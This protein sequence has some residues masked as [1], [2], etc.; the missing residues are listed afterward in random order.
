MSKLLAAFLLLAALTFPSAARDL[1]VYF[2]DV[3]GGQAT[4]V[5]APSGQSLLID[6]GWPGFAGRDPMRIV[7]AAREAGLKQIDYLLVTHYH[8]DHA[9][10]VPALA[11]QF[12][13]RHF[14]DHGPSVETGQSAQD[15]FTAYRRVREQGRH[16]V[17]K[18]GQAIP[19]EGLGIRILSSA[20]RVLAAPPAGAGQA[21]PLCAQTAPQPED[22]GEN[23]QSVGIL[24]TYGKFRLLDLGDLTWNRELEL[25]CPAN[26][27]GPVDVYLTTHHGGDGSGPAAL[28]Q[29]LR[30]R[31]AVMNNGAE[32]GGTPATWQVVRDSPG[33]EDIWQLHFSAEGGRAH[34]APEKF[35]ANPQE[36]C[37]GF[38]LKL[39]AA[40]DGAFTLTNVRQG[41]SKRYNPR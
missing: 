1:E 24:I 20:G 35:I 28:V 5:V 9:G 39:T 40:E 34:N 23:S 31:V 26:Q 25:A 19:I 12:P 14:V 4:L 6:A 21:N 32:K 8:Q 37:R 7:A 22:P 36:P 29:A 27:I 17:A 16:I 2:I 38:A 13:I 18:P 3:E 33:L 10:G 30:P 41:F 11:E 15:L